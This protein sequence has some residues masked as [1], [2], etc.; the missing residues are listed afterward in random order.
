[1]EF[2]KKSFIVNYNVLPP[3]SSPNL[4]S[5]YQTQ[6]GYINFHLIGPVI[7]RSVNYD[8]HEHF[9]INIYKIILVLF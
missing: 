2:T 5:Y 4:K 6:H 7:E 1:M 3:H 8:F 9:R